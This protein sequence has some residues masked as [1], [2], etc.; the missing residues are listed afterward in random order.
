MAAGSTRPGSNSSLVTAK[1]QR[2]PGRPFTKGKSGNP[3]GRPP[4]P[5]EL[6]EV[7]ALCRQKSIA[8]V[9]RLEHWMA[10]DNARVSVAAALGILERAFGRPRQPLEHSTGSNNLALQIVMVPPPA[11]K[12]VEAKV[13]DGESR[14]LEMRR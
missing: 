11:P 2:G 14:R 6:A 8:A 12:P 1:K 13:I 7:E 3:S 5:P 4:D 9:E 10:S